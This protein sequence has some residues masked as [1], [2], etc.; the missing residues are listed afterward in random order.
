M[1]IRLQCRP[2]IGVAQKLAEALDVHAAFHAPCRVGMPH[3]MKISIAGT[4]AFQQLPIPVL[5]CARLHWRV[6][7]G[8][9]VVIFLNIL[10]GCF[11]Q[12]QHMITSY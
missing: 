12:L 8:Q 7:I 6:R 1:D 10:R 3:S 11:Q 4:A 2:N 5:Q 9:Q